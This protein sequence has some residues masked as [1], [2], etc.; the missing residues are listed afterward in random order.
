MLKLENVNKYFNKGNKNEIHVINNTSLE[1]KD[2]GLIAILGES[3][4]R[5]NYTF[6]CNK[7]TG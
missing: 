4:S 5:K 7:W 6:K 1:F 3:G 2:N